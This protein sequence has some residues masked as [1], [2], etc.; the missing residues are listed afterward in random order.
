MTNK[1][2]EPETSADARIQSDIN[3]AT[4]PRV[5]ARNDEPARAKK[6]PALGEILVERKTLTIIG[7]VKPAGLKNAGHQIATDSKGNLY[8]A[9]TTNGLQK[10]T[11]K[12]MSPAG[13]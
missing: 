1:S 7:T 8:L 6:G 2:P 9:Q 3:V 4:W 11:F 13:K 5:V 12:G 10:L